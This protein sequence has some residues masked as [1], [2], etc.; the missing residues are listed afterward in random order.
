MEEYYPKFYENDDMPEQGAF[1]QSQQ[2]GTSMYMPVGVQT[3]LCL[4]HF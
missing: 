1:A 4:P 3:D 2:T